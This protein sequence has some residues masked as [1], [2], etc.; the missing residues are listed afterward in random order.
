MQTKFYDFLMTITI[1]ANIN[2]FRG[3]N[4]A[5]QLIQ[6]NNRRYFKLFM[7]NP[8]FVCF[9]TIWKLLKKGFKNSYICENTEK[10]YL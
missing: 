3:A 4:F 8:E 5:L 9:S 1:L 10:C 2:C 6:L 7:N